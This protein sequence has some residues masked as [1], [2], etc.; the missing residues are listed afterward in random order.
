[1]LND[2]AEA[3]LSLIV[4][5]R[6]VRAFHLAL[7]DVVAHTPD[8]H[9]SWVAFARDVEIDQRRLDRTLLAMQEVLREDPPAYLLRY[10]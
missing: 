9:P 6:C 7:C 10:S 1:M 4:A 3:L 8:I 5:Q 2:P